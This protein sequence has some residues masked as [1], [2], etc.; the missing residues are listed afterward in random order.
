MPRG[1]EFI[2]QGVE[3][4]VLAPEWN[5]TNE[6]LHSGALQMF[7][8]NRRVMVGSPLKLFTKWWETGPRFEGVYGVEDIR[9]HAQCSFSVQAKW[10]VPVPMACAVKIGVRLLGC[11]SETEW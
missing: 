8:M 10:R 11:M 7:V 3:V 6:V 4:V 5:V 1:F 2:V 9:L